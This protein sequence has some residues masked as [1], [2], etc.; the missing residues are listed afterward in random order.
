MAHMLQKISKMFKR[1]QKMLGLFFPRSKAKQVPRVSLHNE[2]KES[3][4]EQ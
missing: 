4:L 1:L 3:D 2:K